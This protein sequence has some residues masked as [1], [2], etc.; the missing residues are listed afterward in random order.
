MPL[1]VIQLMLSKNWHKQKM[2]SQSFPCEYLAKHW[3]NE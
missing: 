1:S 2:V 3:D